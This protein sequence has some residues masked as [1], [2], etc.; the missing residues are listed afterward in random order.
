VL[1]IE[2]GLVLLSLPI[3]LIYPGLGSRWFEKLEGRFSQLSRKHVFSVVLVGVAA[4][5]LRAA[6]LPIEPIPEPIVHD[7]FG[8]LLAAD[9]FAHGRLTNPTH[10]MW[11]HF[12]TFSIL[13]KPTY[14]CYA[15]P[16][17]GMILAFG[18]FFLGHPFW[19]VWLS[20]SVMCAS[21]T[22]MLQGWLAPEWALLGGVLAILRYGTFGYWANS[23][24]GGAIGAIGG[25]LVLGALPRIKSSQRSRDA[26]L[27]G[28]GLAVLAGSRPY[29]G[30]VFSLP[31]ALLLFSWM[32]GKNRPSFQ[33]CLFRIVL[34]LALMLAIASA[35]MTYY[36]WR[37]TGNPFRMPYQIV[38][39]TYLVAPYMIWQPV[40]PE[41]VY[42][43]EILRKM[44]TGEALGNYYIS[45]SLTGILLKLYTAWRFYFAAA[46]LLPVAMLTLTLP[47]NVSL[48]S[49]K[50]RTLS[51]LFVFGAVVV[52]VVVSTFYNP[53]YSAPATGLIL[54]LVLVALQQLRNWSKSGLF[55]A[56]AFVVVCL[57]TFALRAAADYLHIPVAKSALSAWYQRGLE[58]FGRTH[59]ENQLELLRGKHLVIVCYK[60]E[61]EIFKEWVYND[62]DIDN[63]KVVWARDMNSKANQELINYF[64]D[65][66]VW[67]LDAD[68]KSPKLSP[69]QNQI[70]NTANFGQEHGIQ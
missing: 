54:A 10:P 55:L 70:R 11:I 46:F 23:Y 61:H 18:K 62:A 16:I 53:H 48:R 5:V 1:L 19:G 67:L 69:W 45:R 30:F 38:R 21:I 44:Y 51:L 34:P 29:E 68:A 17:Q 64:N 59:I 2:A 8:Y 58:P 7:E 27:M 47:T 41:P 66:D 32:L 36:F 33:K 40:R 31:I 42:H 28:V 52:G 60:P 56:R 6:L 49:I 22:W 63:A 15:Q 3:A 4:L 13:Q 20:I 14:Q 37:V 43:H 12:E 26:V 50:P 9:T 24:W 35:A 39:D 25:A 57:M 65:R